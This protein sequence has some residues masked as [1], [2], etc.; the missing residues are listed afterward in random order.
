MS[1]HITIPDQDIQ[2]IIH[3][4]HTAHS[5]HI[6]TVVEVHIALHTAIQV[7]VDILVTVHRVILLVEVSTQEEE[8]HSAAHQEVPVQEDTKAIQLDTIPLK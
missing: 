2:L 1:Q 3:H 8:H 6:I 4:T 5:P 7:A